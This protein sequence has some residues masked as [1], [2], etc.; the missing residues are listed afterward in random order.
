MTTEGSE[1][2]Q[3]AHL[4]LPKRRSAGRPHDVLGGPAPGT[5]T[6]ERGIEAAE[7]AGGG[8][9]EGGRQVRRT[10]GARWDMVD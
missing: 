2:G 1:L 9:S 3:D 5:A 4:L 10:P 7:Q 8:G 6:H